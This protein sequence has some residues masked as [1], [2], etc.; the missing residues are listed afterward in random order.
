[1]I[2]SLGLLTDRHWF[3]FELH[4]DPRRGPRAGAGPVPPVNSRGSGAHDRL[5]R[6]PFGLFVGNAT[7]DFR[8]TPPVEANVG[9]HVRT[10]QG[11]PAEFISA[12]RELSSR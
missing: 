2:R 12:G 1:M 9:G 3:E 6:N 11:G 7:S 4:S 10:H 8:R 5:E